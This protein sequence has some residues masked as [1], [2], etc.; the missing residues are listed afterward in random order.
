VGNQIKYQNKNHQW[1]KYQIKTTK[2]TGCELITKDFPATPTTTKCI[3]RLNTFCGLN[4]IEEYLPTDSF[5]C[6][7]IK[8][9]Y[10]PY[11]IVLS[12]TCETPPKEDGMCIRLA[13]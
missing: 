5:L 6:C 12:C 9:Y 4:G 13:L 3:N 11:T 10:Q 2:N 8:V 7:T 1:K